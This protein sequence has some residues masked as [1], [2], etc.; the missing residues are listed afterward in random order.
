LSRFS[1]NEKLFN[2]SKKNVILN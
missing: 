1:T 2:L